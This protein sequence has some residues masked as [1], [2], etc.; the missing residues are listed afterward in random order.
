MQISRTVIAAVAVVAMSP[1]ITAHAGEKLS[2]EEIAALFPGQYEAIWKD[3]H[4][5]QVEADT[6]GEISGSYGIFFGSGKWW[7]AGDQLCVDSHWFSKKRCSAV[8]RQGE[9]F[10]GM[11]N[12]KGKPR[13][14]FRPL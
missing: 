4:E 1:P 6:D 7:I 2:A 13:V 5:V 9:W 14:R 10:M 12:G 8:E 11:H 3:K